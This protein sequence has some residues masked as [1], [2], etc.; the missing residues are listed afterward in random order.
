MEEADEYVT[1]SSNELSNIRGPRLYKRR[2]RYG[3]IQSAL[4]YGALVWENVRKSIKAT[5]RRILRVALS[6]R[7]ASTEGLNVI[8]AIPPIDFLIQVRNRKTTYDEV[9]GLLMLMIVNL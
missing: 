4:L 8:T 5:Q 7:T 2:V 9:I 3:V 6:Y 1:T